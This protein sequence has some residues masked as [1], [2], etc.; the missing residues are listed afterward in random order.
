MKTIRL[1][2]GMVLLLLLITL[3]PSPIKAQQ[4]KLEFLKGTHVFRRILFEHQFKSL[5]SPKEI[6]DDPSHTLVVVLGTNR[7]S[8]GPVKPPDET[9][10]RPGFPNILD[11]FKPKTA[12]KEGFL[13]R[14]PPTEWPEVK[15]QPPGM[16][17]VAGTLAE[18]A[19]SALATSQV[20]S[21]NRT[22]IGPVETSSQNPDSDLQLASFLA[23][24]GSILYASDHDATAEFESVGREI[25]GLTGYKVGNTIMVL[26]PSDNAADYYRDP[27]CPALKTWPGAEPDLLK[28]SD[29]VKLN[30]LPVATNRP[31]RL[32]PVNRQ[33]IADCRPLLML[34]DSLY[35]TPRPG[36]RRLIGT[37]GESDETGSGVDGNGNRKY[38]DKERIFGVLRE[39]KSGNGKLLFLADHSVFINNMMIPNDNANIEFASRC[40][41]FLCKRE[42][43][44]INRVLL[45]DHGDISPSLEISL[46]EIPS[47]LNEKVLE[48]ALQSIDPTLASMEDKNVFDD[49]IN[50]MFANKGIGSSTLARIALVVLSILLLFWMALR[51]AN[52]RKN[53]LEQM[54]DATVGITG[55][56]KKIA[57][58]PTKP[59]PRDLEL[60]KLGNL[61]EPARAM[62][63]NVWEGSNK[64]IN[65]SPTTNKTPRFLV[66]GSLFERLVKRQ[67]AQYLWR[68]A[69]GTK[70]DRIQ[71]RTWPRFLQRLH[72]LETDL[73]NG[74]LQVRHQA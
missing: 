57:S 20:G 7:K 6:N 36:G 31:S 41:D 47:G 67:R 71:P 53:R 2:V 73:R 48:S 29:R 32:V 51:V 45:L 16:S 49:A 50:Q 70:P 69:Y 63:R 68:L 28:L 26:A 38:S 8:I 74:L 3:P 18:A 19:I 1:P 15:K 13:P 43:D 14:T 23:K 61:W 52:S 33:T 60:E 17:M 44:P 35:Q 55:K 58:A 12:P 72:Q 40:I 64:G 5:K 11:W 59:A 24:G 30:Q 56:T 62:A 37:G 21:G 54:G 34:P 22:L 25:E 9:I 46:K 27:Q 42:N 10:S 4:D 66:S 65:P 39:R